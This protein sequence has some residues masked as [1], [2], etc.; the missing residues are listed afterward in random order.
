MIFLQATFKLAPSVDLSHQYK[1]NLAVSLSNTGKNEILS[2][3]LEEFHKWPNVILCNTKDLPKKCLPK[4][5]HIQ[6]RHLN[7]QFYVK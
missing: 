7:L 1:G 3:C 4:H 5:V 6:S 2:P